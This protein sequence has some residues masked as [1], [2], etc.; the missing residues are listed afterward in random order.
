VGER[1]DLFIF[2][3]NYDEYMQRVDIA[4]IAEFDITQVIGLNDC[5]TNSIK[6][7]NEYY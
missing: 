5:V 1:G 6:L 4:I 3:S 7:Y 2:A